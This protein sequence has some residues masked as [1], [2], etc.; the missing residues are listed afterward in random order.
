MGGTPTGGEG[1]DMRESLRECVEGVLAAANTIAR[2][3][4]ES[5]WRTGAEASKTLLSWGSKLHARLAMLFEF[6]LDARAA[7]AVDRAVPRKGKPK[8]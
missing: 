5:D 4:E 7:A 6:E 1:G 2:A 3:S 8:D